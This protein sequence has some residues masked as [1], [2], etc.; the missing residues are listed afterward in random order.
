MPKRTDIKK[1]K[2]KMKYRKSVI[3]VEN[4]KEENED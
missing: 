4:E 1:V 3:V 2:K